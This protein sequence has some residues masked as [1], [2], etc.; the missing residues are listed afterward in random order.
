VLWRLVRDG[1]DDRWFSATGRLGDVFEVRVVKDATGR[2]EAFADSRHSRTLDRD[3]VPL[4]EAL[5]AS[6]E[7]LSKSE[8]KTLVAHLVPKNRAD[9]AISHALASGLWVARKGKRNATLCWPAD[10]AWPERVDGGSK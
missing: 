8:I 7:P 5:N 6:D 2:L 9:A 3:L 10:R 4:C 1:D